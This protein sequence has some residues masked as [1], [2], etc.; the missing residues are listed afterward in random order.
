MHKELNIYRAENGWLVVPYDLIETRN[1]IGDPLYVA[2]DMEQLL[3]L[4]RELMARE[5]G[6]TAEGDMVLERVANFQTYTCTACGDY[7]IPDP[8]GAAYRAH[9][10]SDR[11]ARNSQ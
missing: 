1:T 3:T 9:L 2:R 11:H 4:V 7:S 5:G 8:D 10:M 6:L